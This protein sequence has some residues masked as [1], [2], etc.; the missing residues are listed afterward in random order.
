MSLCT[1]YQ[2]CSKFHTHTLTHTRCSSSSFTV[3][4]SLIRRTACARAQ[5]SGYSSTTNANSGTGQMAVCCQNL[6]LGALSSR[7]AL[8]VLVGAPLKKFGLFLNTPRI[9][10]YMQKFSKAVLRWTVPQPEAT[11]LYKVVKKELLHIKLMLLGSM[12]I[13]QMNLS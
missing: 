7:S 6:T 5:F 12:Y 13:T 2:D 4:L 9:P 3:T 11:H 1:L 10:G 8:S